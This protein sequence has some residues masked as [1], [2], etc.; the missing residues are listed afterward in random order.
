[1]S[2]GPRKLMHVVSIVVVSFLA[3]L[4]CLALTD[5]TRANAATHQSAALGV[6]PHASA[7]TRAA[8]D[9][10]PV[11]GWSSW[12]F[13]RFGVD[14]QRI[15]SEAKA[16]VSTGLARHGYRYVNIDDN[17]YDCPGPQGP[18]VDQYG[19]WVVNDQ[20]FPSVN[21]MNGIAAVAAYVHHLGLKFGIYETAGISKQAVAANTP[22]LGTPYTADEIATNQTQANYNCGGMVDLNYS[23]PGAQAYVDSVVDQLAQWG[24]DYIKLDGITDS[25]GAD[26]QAWS[27]A[28]AQSG[29][30]IVLDTTEGQFDT[31]LA[32]VLDQ[33]SNQWEFSPDIE[34][35]GPD[36][37]SANGCNNPPYT[38]CLSVFPL[39]SYAAWSDRFDGV[40]TW[41]PYGGP[42]GFNDY[43][44]I[45]VGDGSADSGMS[46]AA[47]ESQL[48]LWALGS[49]PLILGSDLTS[50]VTNAFGSSAGLT[51]S[52]LAMLENPGVIEIDQDSI[53]A[54][55]IYDSADSQIF[56]K[57]EPSGDAAVGLFDTDQAAT[58]QPEMITTTASALGL[59]ASRAGYR[60]QNVWTGAA[61]RI[62]AAGAI[63]ETVAPE[64]V[65]L[66]RVTPIGVAR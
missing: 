23:A 33:Y 12:S 45:E 61:Q 35:N 2:S 24:V 38:G 64:G 8:A 59:P 27:N 5:A 63:A 10:T 28:I 53:D 42:G 54:A 39:T 36:E 55:R 58:A 47:E 50:S 29:R 30:S 62:S 4:A 44:S 48:S 16:L 60:V 65:A 20:E 51:P 14:T 19:R 1:M 18:D 17:W 9:P 26:I 49:A 32:P 25:N 15:E 40:A 37:G 56:S 3:A 34:I 41:Q 57:R 43:D 13:L 52:G 66:L 31:K 46:P 11:M 6:R 22:I 21:G 7:P